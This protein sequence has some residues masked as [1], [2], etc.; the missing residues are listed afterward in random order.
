MQEHFCLS[1]LKSRKTYSRRKVRGFEV[2]EKLVY[3]IIEEAGNKGMDYGFFRFSHTW[4]R[5]RDFREIA[6]SRMVSDKN[7]NKVY[8]K[9]HQHI[10]LGKFYQAYQLMSKKESVRN[11][12]YQ[13]KFAEVN[14]IVYKEAFTC[15][16]LSQM[17]VINNGTLRPKPL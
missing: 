3:Q 15:E 6:A 17:D 13:R 14:L 5:V 2:E 11:F 12:S 8:Q 16:F 7:D 4:L 9:E 10:F 1:G